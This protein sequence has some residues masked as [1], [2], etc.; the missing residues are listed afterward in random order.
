MRGMT[1]QQI[2]VERTEEVDKEKK[3]KRRPRR[4]KQNPA[5][6]G[7]NDSPVSGI[8]M[9][10]SR[11]LMNNDNSN[12]VTLSM[13]VSSAQY[14]GLDV[15]TSHDHGLATA[16]DVTFHS[17][18]TMH[19]N[20]ETAAVEL[21][22]T[23]DE[24]MFPPDIGLTV[25]S[26]SCPELICS[27]GKNQ[28]FSNKE[29]LYF[30]KNEGNAGMQRNYFPP[31]WSVEAV[32]EAIEKGVAFKASFRVNAYN[33]L[34]AYCTIE[35]VPTDIFISGV[36]NQ[37]RAVSLVVIFPGVIYCYST[38]QYQLAFPLAMKYIFYY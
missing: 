34:E 8:R 1:E 18:P 5:I 26:K 17:L 27:E 28:S 23:Q 12:H 20:G 7:S 19:I 32:N 11:C 4:S 14:Y 35:G 36:P 10:E 37:N 29:A 24:Q 6:S 33:R 21:G 38:V 9:Q 25:L 13:N 15:Q 22:S 3:K 2:T 16:S 31:H 30:H